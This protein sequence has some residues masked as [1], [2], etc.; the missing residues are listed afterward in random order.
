MAKA[1]TSRTTFVIA[2]GLLAVAAAP[3]VPRAADEPAAPGQVH[4]LYRVDPW[5]DGA[6]I[7]VSGLGYLI[8]LQLEH[9]LITPRCPCDRNEVPGFERWAI[10]LN[11]YTAGLLADITYS[12]AVTGP[13]IANYFLVGPTHVWLEDTTVLAEAIALS[14]GL[15]T[16]FKY[17]VQ[18]P[19]PR[20]YA[21][22]PAVLHVPASYRSFYSGHVATVVTSL[23]VVAWTARLRYGEMVWPWVVVGVAGLSVSA[24]LVLSGGHFPSDCFV[25]ILTGLAIGTAVPLL[26]VIPGAAK[27]SRLSLV[28]ARNGLALRWTFY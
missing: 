15:L 12:L 13:L 20:A 10:G 6:I 17:T 27:Q 1:R 28:P 2:L 16:I 23:T 26:H 11:N 4:S 7:I 24:E 18:R 14:G 25:G 19:I 8:P 3:A 5:V 9:V 21:N 22:D